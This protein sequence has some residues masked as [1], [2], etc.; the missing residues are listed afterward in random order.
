MLFGRTEES[1]GGEISQ[2]EVGHQEW[3]MM[4]TA[5]IH[6]LSLLCF[7]I[8]TGRSVPESLP[9]PRLLYPGGLNPQVMSQNKFF[10]LM[11]LLAGYLVTKTRK[12]INQYSIAWR[13]TK[14]ISTSVKPRF[15]AQNS[16]FWTNKLVEGLVAKTDVMS[17]VPRIHLVEGEDRFS[18]ALLWLSHAHQG[19]Y[20]HKIKN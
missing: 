11:V 20:T 7:L 3:P 9:P 10:S 17:S 4:L 6:F 16:S 13:E 8:S 12:V 15:I 18:W 1:L 14:F 2:K 5:G 19:R